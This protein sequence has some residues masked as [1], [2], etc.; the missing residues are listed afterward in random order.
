MRTASESPLAAV[1]D[2]FRGLVYFPVDVKYKIIA[3]LTPVQEKKVIILHTSDGK[4]QHYMEYAHAE[5]ELN[6]MS[7]SLLI[8]EV[9]EEGPYRGTLFLAFGD[10]T[11][12]IETYGAG[13]YLRCKK[14]TW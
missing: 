9:I 12:A 4:E 14:S 5:F 11:S 1:K 13:R 3:T 2:E 6:G 8:L 10:E 7:N